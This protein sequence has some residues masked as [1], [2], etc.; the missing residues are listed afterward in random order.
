[1]RLHLNGE[2]KKSKT[3]VNA[4]PNIGI[5]SGSYTYSKG[6]RFHRLRFSLSTQCKVH[7]ATYDIRN[8]LHF[9]IPSTLNGQNNV[10]PIQEPG[11]EHPVITNSSASEASSIVFL[12][13]SSP[14]QLRI[15]V[16]WFPLFIVISEH[17]DS[18][19]HSIVQSEL[20]GQLIVDSAHGLCSVHCILQGNDSVQSIV[21]VAVIDWSN[22]ANVEGVV[23]LSD[24]LHDI[25][26]SS[27]TAK[28]SNLQANDFC[29]EQRT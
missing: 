13:L 12:Q 9:A 29:R 8:I 18:P 19:L 1:M 11:S 5:C 7:V 26:Q 16:D 22:N 4:V 2:N 27:K 14:K 23:N 28:A 15:T 20:S 21:V 17:T 10:T 3:E 25:R 24:I 6:L